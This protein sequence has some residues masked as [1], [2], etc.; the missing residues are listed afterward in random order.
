MISQKLVHLIETHAED[1]TVRWLKDVRVHVDT[2][3]YHTFPEEKLC[4]RACYVYAHLGGWGAR[5]TARRWSSTTARS[6]RSASL[7]VFP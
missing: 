7:R 6:G 3:T 5:S 1:L 4:Q 2:P